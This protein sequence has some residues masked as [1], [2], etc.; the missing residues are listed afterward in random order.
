MCSSDLVWIPG[1][2][3][4]EGTFSVAVA[5]STLEPIMVHFWSPDSLSF[6]VIDTMEGESARGPYAGQFPGVVRPLLPWR[7][8]PVIETCAT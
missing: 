2:F 4:S 1:N 3:L 5:L 6:Q 7:T 8:V